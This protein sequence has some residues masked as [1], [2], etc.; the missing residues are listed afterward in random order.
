MGLTH[1]FFN[2]EQITDEFLAI[3]K[4]ALS[5]I[6]KHQPNT[7]M[8][9]IYRIIHDNTDTFRKLIEYLARDNQNYEPHSLHNFLSYE[10]ESE[11]IMQH[12]DPEEIRSYSPPSSFPSGRR[13]GVQLDPN[14]FLMIPQSYNELISQNLPRMSTTRVQRQSRVSENR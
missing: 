5:N 7:G 2:D 14:T 6:R 11:P 3:T 8:K 13:N 12:E 9:D 1:Q 10:Q 4:T